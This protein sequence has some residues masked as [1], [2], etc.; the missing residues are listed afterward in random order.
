MTNHKLR[1]HG[2]NILECES[3]LKLLASSLNGGVFQLKSGPAYAPTYEFESDH[4]EYF[5][6]QLF[7]GY[8]RW[9]FP[10][11]EYIASLGG[12]LR[13]APDAIITRLEVE[14]GILYE[15]PILAFEFSG[16][17]PAGN[18]AWQ[19]T[20]RALALA[21]AG[22]PYLYFAELG[23]QELDAKRVIKAA[24]FPN[25]LVPFAYAVL[26]MSS[27]SISLPVY[28]P[29]PSSHKDIIE[30]YKDCFGDKESIELVRAILLS[31]DTKNTINRIEKKVAKI[32]EILS[33]QRK[34]TGSILKPTEWAEF[35]N[36]K[37]GL[38]KANWLIKKAMPWNKKTSIK[39]L[40]PTFKLLLKAV[41]KVRAVAIG[42]KDMPI[43]IIS[44]ENRTLFANHIKKIYKRKISSEFEDWVSN[45]SRPLVCVW[46]A[47]FKPRG[48]D[49]RPDRGLVPMA[50][51]IFGLEDVDVLTVI[52]GPAKP[53]TWLLLEKDM[54]KLAA[55]NG[56]WEAIINLSNG[57]IIDS[58]TGRSLNNYGF[59]ID[60]KKDNFKKELLPAANDVPNFGEHDVDSVLHLLFSNATG[61][62]IHESLCNPP[63]GDWSGISVLNFS[64]GQEFRW[65]SLPRVSGLKSKRPDHLVQLKDTNNFLS[66]ESKDLEAKLENKIG[67]RLIDYVKALLQ[68]A[69]T[70]FREK[71]I[72]NWNQY[73]GK[74]LPDA[75]FLSGAAFRFQNIKSLKLALVRAKVDI[76]FGVEFKPEEKQTILHIVTT[77]QGESILP[78][79]TKLS[80]RL[81]GLITL[82]HY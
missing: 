9:G 31:E 18:N 45:T 52:Y 19:R 5:E 25:P 14:G 16:A 12:T 26:G 1:I 76:V 51:M 70:A 60:K 36:Q 37:S 22:I 20:G 7:P 69:P 65:T 21:Y 34:R 3:A 64:S 73:V 57:L 74:K 50:R 49:S 82:K 32:L 13:E 46:V 2:D 67:P 66:I 30:I 71:G 48:D 56:L 40:T 54:W 28:I 43:C 35:Y 8:G 10:L 15:R 39:T 63:G 75:S 33:G 42:S 80:Q 62:G 27:K 6:V 58:N 77:K 68:K 11:V 47:G 53:L 81:G 79:I 59:L 61:Y 17:L 78:L 4:K 29:S 41:S 38:D 72:V 23:G 44:P 55:I 24:R